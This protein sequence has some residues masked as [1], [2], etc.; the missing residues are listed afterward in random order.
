M[1]EKK[2][3]AKVICFSNHKGGVG[4]T[5]SA[6][7]IGA[8]LA[9]KKKKILLIDIDPQ[10]NLTICCGIRDTNKNIY[11]VLTGSCSIAES[12]LNIGVNQSLVPGTLDLAGAEIELISEPGREIILKQAIEEVCYLYDYILIDCPPSLGL[13]TTNALTAADEVIIPLQAEFLAVNGIEKLID[14]TEKVKKRLN[15]SLKIGG[16]IITR[17]DARKILNRD[18]ANKIEQ[19]YQKEVFKTK[20]RENI[21]LAEAPSNG[22]DIFRYNPKSTGAADYAAVCDEILT[23]N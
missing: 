9:R 22:Q 12:I 15:K 11:S 17:Y 13:L 1:K 3:K 2:K 14:I 4:K 10:A 7:N 18:I 6:Y 20:I 19:Y 16:V 5:S 21:S 23:R 8:G